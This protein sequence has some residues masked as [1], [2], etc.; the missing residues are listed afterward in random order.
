MLVKAGGAG[1]TDPAA[2][3]R[4]SRLGC[5]CEGNQPGLQY[6]LPAEPGIEAPPA[7]RGAGPSHAEAVRAPREAISSQFTIHYSFNDDYL[8]YAGNGTVTKNNGHCSEPSYC[9]AI[10][11][12]SASSMPASSYRKHHA[13]AFSDLRMGA[14]IGR[15]VSL[16]I[17]DPTAARG[18]ATPINRRPGETRGQRLRLDRA[19]LLMAGLKRTILPWKAPRPIRRSR[20]SSCG[21]AIGR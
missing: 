21:A 16:P 1:R 3:F 5:G 7:A 11:A 6:Y 20:L 2:A 9:S 19:G 13:Q 14:G 12:W 15:Q 18:V 10:S 17:S 8:E 4:C